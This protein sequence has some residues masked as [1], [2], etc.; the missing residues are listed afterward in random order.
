LNVA[1]PLAAE[2]IVLG[3]GTAGLA[4][5]AALRRV[6][7]KAV[8][9]EQTDK[10]GASW[11]TRYDGLRL[12]TPGWMSTQPGY[13]ASRRR[14]GEYPS[15]DAWI[16][17]L[18]DYAAHHRI[19]VRFG[20]QVGRVGLSDGGWRVETD[21]GVLGARFV[22]IA[23]GYD[24]EPNLPDWPGREG[25]TGRLIHSSAYQNTEPYRGRDVLVVGPNITGSEVAHFLSKGGAGRVR[26]S[27]R[28]PP[29]VM[30]RK[31]LGVPVQLNGVALHH[32]PLPVADQIIWLGQRMFFGKLDRYGLPRSPLGVAT[33]LR[34][35]QQAPV[36]D[37]GF[38]AG[39]KAGRIEIVAAVEGFDG[40]DV[41][42][43][44]ET[45]IQPDAVIAATGYRRGLQGLVGHLGVLDE[46]GT[47]LV[48]GGDEHPSAPGMFFN[49]YRTELSGQLRLMRPDARA[50][51]RAVRRRRA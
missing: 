35:R 27:R 7:V 33:M 42:L 31:Y 30:R 22:V 26:V 10:V 13:R 49:G 5:A 12:N 2:A 11:R 18:E 24:R 47:P 4:A 45:R 29:N 46:N 44:D 43:A 9:L 25:F 1:E 15:R 21:R 3:A 14:Y 16:Q 17:Y 41:L 28:T 50:I 37:D 48:S 32:V 36:F 40:P 8:V 23:T 19:D 51:A 6:D 39:V 20:T 38:I 34:R